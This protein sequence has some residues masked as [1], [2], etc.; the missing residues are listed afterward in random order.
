MNDWQFGV[1]IKQERWSC[2]TVRV[3]AD[4]EAEARRMA[5]KA[6]EDCD[7]TDMEGFA[8]DCE[9]YWEDGE[10]TVEGIEHD[11]FP[12]GT[13]SADITVPPV[14]VGSAEDMA[15]KEA[16]GQLTLPATRPEGEGK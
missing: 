7:R 13:Y 12:I 4:T 11:E 2:I 1:T 14:E 9:R 5:V 16:A 3:T 10:I 8:G 15:V 6:A